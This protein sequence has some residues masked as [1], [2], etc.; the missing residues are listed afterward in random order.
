MKIKLIIP[1]IAVIF[2]S[3][4][5]AQQERHLSMWN[6]NSSPINPAT[7]ADMQ[8]DLRLLTNFRTQWMTLDG[9]A[10]IT[11][12]FSGEVKLIKNEMN[13]SYLG[14]GANLSKD[15]TGDV[16]FVS[17]ITSVPIA[18]HL[19]LDN[20]NAISVGVAPG[21]YSQVIS[22]GNQTWD[23]QWNGSTFDQAI[24]SGESFRGSTSSFD[25]GAGIQ[26]K[27]SPD[28]NAFLNIGFAVNHINAPEL[29]FTP[30]GAPI[31]RTFN[32]TVSGTRF[33]QL[34]KFGI[35]PQALVSIMGP[36]RNIIL[37]TYF[38][39]EI[40]EGSKRTDYV[41]GTMIS[42]GFFYRYGDA[43]I[44]S[45]MYRYQGLKVGFSYDVN[46]SKLTPTTKSVGGIE[47]FLKYSMMLD[48]SSKIHDRKLF[49]W[50]NNRGGM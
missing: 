25:F 10:F 32:F 39:H 41:N 4:V 13:G 11:N 30:S 34:R 9:K 2:T 8:E 15:Q 17:T 50:R 14:L 5:I 20:Q 38:D 37:G 42:Y 31:F 29:S 7:V 26:Y 18:Y 21:F 40:S 33:N 1:T 46:L 35:S 19:H 16:R 27:Y 47:L 45:L 43:F 44:A 6:E 48:K 23:N 3:Q 36:N 49:R 22:D 28:Q 12:A 24:S